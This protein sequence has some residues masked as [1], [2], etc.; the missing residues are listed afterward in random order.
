[1]ILLIIIYYSLE[2]AHDTDEVHEK[3]K[4]TLKIQSNDSSRNVV[5]LEHEEL[6]IDALD[7]ARRELGI[8][9]LDP[10]IFDSHLHGIYDYCVS[11][12]LTEQEARRFG[13]LFRD[14]CNAV[15]RVEPYFANRFYK[16][17]L[18]YY[19]NEATGAVE[20][21]RFDLEI[22]KEALLEALLALRDE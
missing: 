16:R 21:C 12:R 3:M 22:D 13:D 19:R 15:V 8:P 9:G 10:E 2:V 20:W 17:E 14:C 6:G 18:K 1:M 4:F 5:K 11:L 7:A